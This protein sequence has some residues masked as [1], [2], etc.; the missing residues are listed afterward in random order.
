[1]SI[2]VYAMNSNSGLLQNQQNSVKSTEQKTRKEEGTQAEFQ[3]NVG[4]VQVTQEKYRGD[5]T[6]SVAQRMQ[7]TEAYRQV[8]EGQE[9]SGELQGAVKGQSYSDNTQMDTVVISEEGR[10][11]YSKMSKQEGGVNELQDTASEETEYEVEDLSEYT[12][13][14]LKQMYYQGEI[15]LQEYEDE[16]G[17][18][19]E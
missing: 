7:G 15:T 16:T 12:D 5:G 14:E 3:K 6:I 9:N 4:S 18:T 11:A 2:S 19:M 13:T 10:R 17:E 1:M 8:S